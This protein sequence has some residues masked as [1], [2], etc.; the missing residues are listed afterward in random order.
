ML[1]C[2]A[3]L[4][5]LVPGSS[6]PQ[7]MSRKRRSSPPRPHIVLRPRRKRRGLAL[8]LG[9]AAALGVV[10]LLS[11]RLP[12]QAPLRPFRTEA[13]YRQSGVEARARSAV[14]GVRALTEAV[15]AFPQSRELRLDLGIALENSIT[16]VARTRGTLQPRLAS[17][18]ERLRASLESLAQ[19]E[20]ARRMAPADSRPHSRAGNVYAIWGLWEDAL[21]E[22]ERAYLLG[23]RSEYDSNLA[24]DAILTLRGSAD[25]EYSRPGGKMFW[26]VFPE[27]SILSIRPEHA[28]RG[29]PILP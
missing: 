20:T 28:I 23:D 17:S 4:C 26:A 14:E 3:I 25:P 21:V 5:P 1:R 19:Y 15:H 11:L 12:R 13:A 6:P 10:A 22:F 27:S 29:Y 7:E 16:E 2:R 24:L 9:V 8:W 18:R